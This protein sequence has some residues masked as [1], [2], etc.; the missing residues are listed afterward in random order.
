MNE[1]ILQIIQVWG[2]PVFVIILG[3][4]IGWVFKRYIHSRLIKLADKT[5]WKLDNVILDA[6]GSYVFLWSFL[7]AFFIAS[8][9]ASIAAPWNGYLAKAALTILIL[10][11][12]VVIA[13]IVVGLLQLWADSQG[14]G[15]PSTTIFTNLARIII[16]VIGVLIVLQSLK[17]SI[18]P[19][20]TA[21]GVGGLAVSLALKDTLSDFFAGLHILLS[22]KVKPGD[23]VELDS[24]ERGYITNITWRNTTLME[25]TNNAILI[26]NSR[27]STAIV[28]N[29][30]SKDTQFS[31][32]VPVGVAYD[33]DLRHVER[34]TRE[35]A[36]S[37]MDE[38]EGGVKGYEPLV[39]FFE[40]GDS[41][42][43]LKVYLRVKKYGDHHIVVHEFIERLH[44]R[45][46]EE[47]IEIP[48]PIRT[49]LHK[50]SKG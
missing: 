33:S 27:L 2:V 4:A 43:N 38:V 25:R 22:Q 42:I 44:R 11:I 45:Y 24:G 31:I 46:N 32:R 16:I 36:K 3:L 13:K 28:K 14:A 47:G 21:L 9:G 17:I 19:L 30:D 35:V 37:V 39:R 7:E 49:V 50:N 26:P 41:S 8:S 18:T 5:N 1:K 48:F 23:F 12:T 40:F 20:L 34:I 15:F 29:Y 10:S 6:T